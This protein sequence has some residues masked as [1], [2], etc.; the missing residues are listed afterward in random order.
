[1][2]QWQQ[3]NPKATLTEIEMAIETELAQ[4]RKQLVEEMVEKKAAT[5]TEKPDCLQCGGKMVKN[6]RRQRKL[7][8]K[9]RQTIELN[10]QQWRCLPGETSLFPSWIGTFFHILRASKIEGGGTQH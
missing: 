4:L 2:A 5:V 1:M 10:R 7:K 3:A 6:G 9:E 8:E